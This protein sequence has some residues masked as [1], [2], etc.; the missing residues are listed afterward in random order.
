MN[1]R[2]QNIGGFQIAMNDSLEVGIMHGS[3]QRLQEFHR[4]MGS[5]LGLSQ[6]LMQ[7]A[8]LDVFHGQKGQTVL[9]AHFEY[10]DDI[11]MM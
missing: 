5:E 10:L 3:S 2:Q 1:Q 7:T 6:M 11:G 9:L 8:A 4:F